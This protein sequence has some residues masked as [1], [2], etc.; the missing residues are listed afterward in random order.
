MSL[1]GKVLDFDFHLSKRE[2][3]EYYELGR[4]NGIQEGIELSEQ[5]KILKSAEL[6]ESEYREIIDFLVSKKVEITYHPLYKGL[7]IRR[8]IYE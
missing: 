3:E 5:R 8:R 6:T 2:R 1:F 7:Q 4:H